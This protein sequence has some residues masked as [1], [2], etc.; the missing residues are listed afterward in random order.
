METL[1]ALLFYSVAA[2]GL[3]YI[4]GHAKISL[5]IRT[6]LAD[7]RAHR[8]AQWRFLK[9]G[10][11]IPGDAFPGEHKIV[12]GVRYPTCP[13]CGVTGSAEQVLKDRGPLTWLV[14]LLECPACFGTHVGFWA[15][16]LFPSS[17]LALLPGTVALCMPFGPWGIGHRFLAGVALA[18]WTC[19]VGFI[20][21]RL[22]GWIRED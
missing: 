21:G 10:H 15:G 5:G 19:A 12:K 22:T 6:K 13:I 16:V 14:E 18:L 2:F 8:G 11:V 7:W 17:V 3:A 1:I 4:V 20:L 9:C